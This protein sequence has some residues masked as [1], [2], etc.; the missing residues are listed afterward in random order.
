MNLF[1]SLPNSEPQATTSIDYFHPIITS[2]TH[3][4]TPSRIPSQ[5]HIA[6]LALR[7]II[8]GPNSKSG[9]IEEPAAHALQ[10]NFSKSLVGESENRERMQKLETLLH[11]LEGEEASTPHE[12]NILDLYAPS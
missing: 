5:K 3:F 10:Q 9:A 2:S 1:P 12:A 6:P 8:S 7:V 4:V 11:H